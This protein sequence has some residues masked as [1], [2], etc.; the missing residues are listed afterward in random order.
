MYHKSN[1]WI[2][3]LLGLY[4]IASPPPPPM[5]PLGLLHFLILSLLLKKMKM[6]ENG[7]GL[8][9]SDTNILNFSFLTIV[10]ISTWP[11]DKICVHTSA[12]DGLKT[13]ANCLKMLKSN[14]AR[15]FK[16]KEASVTQDHVVK[17]KVLHS[18]WCFLRF[19]TEM[20]F[21]LRL[22]THVVYGV[23]CTL[24]DA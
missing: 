2:T 17:T 10:E 22:G 18:M 12:A 14:R 19:W 15:S 11:M 3:A 9:I 6:A 4:S 16:S 23:S 13:F 20:V 5:F 21:S 24:H 1:F 8:P 7:G